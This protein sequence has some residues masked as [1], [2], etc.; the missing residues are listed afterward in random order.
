M[1]M[2]LIIYTTKNVQLKTE[3]IVQTKNEIT[4]SLSIKN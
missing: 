2:A 4:L 3:K 1:L